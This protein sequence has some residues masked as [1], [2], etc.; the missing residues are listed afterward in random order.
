M[1]F[2][3]RVLPQLIAIHENV[4]IR[5]MN[6]GPRLRGFGI[7]T[8]VL[9]PKLVDAWWLLIHCCQSELASHHD[10]GGEFRGVGG[11]LTNRDSDF[12]FVHRSRLILL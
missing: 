11:R 2:L 8:L 5:A 3:Q 9:Y 1:V 6:T 10:F 12:D 4:S 7:T